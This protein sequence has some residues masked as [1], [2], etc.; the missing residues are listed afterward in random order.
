M[1]KRFNEML[2]I[3]VYGHRSEATGWA[4]VYTCFSKAMGEFAHVNCWTDSRSK[5]R[6]SFYKQLLR[7]LGRKKFYGDF[8]VVISGGASHPQT[9]ACWNVWE[10]TRLPLSQRELCFS[11]DYVW[12]PSSWGRQNLIANGIQP[13]KVFIVPEGVDNDFFTPGQKHSGN[14]RFLMV[15]KWEKRK[16]QDGLIKAFTAEFHP[17]ENVEL[18]LHAHN[19][20]IKGFSMEKKLED[21]GISN[22][23][24]IRL[25]EKCDPVSLRALYRSANCFVM[26]TRAEGWGLPILESMACGVPAIVTRYSAP[27]DFVTDDNG[28]LLDVERLV[29]AHDDDFAIHSGQ[30]AEPDIRHLRFLMRRA[31]ENQDEVLAKGQAAHEDAQRFSW[32]NSAHTAYQTIVKHLE[33]VPG[34]GLTL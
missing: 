32:R 15:G 17:K 25:S 7:L 6:K 1:G 28:Y 11:T 12:T 31:F 30:W 26:P 33:Q 2:K 16:F 5:L 21:L 27:V 3:D 20:Y 29:D 8:G 10:T 34:S 22:G 14:F 24:N 18:I 9:T 13:E 23:N 19:S 4:T